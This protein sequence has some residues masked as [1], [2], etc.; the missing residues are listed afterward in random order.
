MV[1]PRTSSTS[2][3]SRV[4]TGRAWARRWRWQALL[5]ASFGLVGAS[6]L[7]A[8][9]AHDGGVLLGK[10]PVLQDGRAVGYVTSANY[11]YAVRKTIAYAYLPKD[12]S[13]I[14]TALEVEYLGARHAATGSRDPQ[15]DPEG[16]RLKG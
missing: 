15:Y 4:P 7:H 12:M 2:G 13:G 11:G 3:A 1:E 5:A 10:E 14:G 8:Q 9:T 16:A 6:A